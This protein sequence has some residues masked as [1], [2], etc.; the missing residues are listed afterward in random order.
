LIFRYPL[1]LT[2]GM[3]L[4]M[5]RKSFVSLC[6]AGIAAVLL[7]TV[8]VKCQQAA[9]APGYQVPP[10]FVVEKV[11]GPP[12]VRYPLFGA[13]DDKGRLYVAEGTGTNL[14]GTE[15]AKK[16]LGRILLLEDTD[17]DGRFDTS[18]VFADDL[19][20]PQG[21]LW[22]DGALYS[23]SHP[24]FWR[25]E[26]TKGTGKADRRIELAT[27][28]NFNG[29]GCDIHGP[30][31][32]PDGRLYWTDGR[33]GYKLRTREGKVLEGLASRIWRCRT[34]GSE[35]ERIA[36]GGFDNPVQVA[37]TPEGEVIGTMD[38]GQG[39]ALLHYVEGGV[40]PMDHPCL[41]E[42]VM[43]GPLLG[44]IRNYSA[45]L[46]AALCG[47]TAYRSE[48]LGKEFKDTFFSTQ[49]MLH[50]IVNHRMIRDGST[51]R[52]EDKDF[53]TSSVHDVHITDAFED[54]DGSLLFIDMGAWF[55]Y[56]FPHNPIPK[57]EV[58]GGIY[59]IRRTD[60]KPVADPWGKALKLAERTAAELTPMLDDPRPRV[61]DQV[62]ALL[63]KT[64]AEAVP[65]LKTIVSS[66][67]HSIEARRNAVWALC[68]IPIP[69]AR[70]AL[71]L[72]LADKELSVRLAA[73]H[74]VSVE[75]D[76][77]ASDALVSLVQSDEPP[78]RLKSAEALGRIGKPG[79]VPALLDSLRKGG[80]RFLE[81]ALIYALIRIN[82][83]AA[84]L[85][86]LE[87]LDPKVRQA[88][89]IAL[90][91]MPAG[92][93]TRDLVVPLLD[94]DDAGLQHTALAVI[95]KRPGWSDS[96]QGLLRQWLEAPKLSAA[97]ER[98]LTG[99]LL[100]FSGEG[101]IQKLVAESLA[102]EATA[103]ATQLLLLSVM[104]RCR[105]DALPETWLRAIEKGLDERNLPVCREAVATVKSR[106]L[107]GFDARLTALGR[108]ADLP[109]D[110]RIAAL[111]CMAERRQALDA[112]SYRLL[113][114]HL[115]EKT[116]PL[117]RLSAART[118]GGGRL[119]VDQLRQ[120]TTFLPAT[121]TMVLRL[122]LPAYAKSGDGG[123]GKALVAA[124]KRTPTAEALAVDELDKVLKR[125][126]PEV[127]QL[128]RP[129]LEKL[130]LGQRKQAEYL[131][132]L[133]AE[134]GQLQGSVD[135]GRGVFFSQKAACYACHRAAGKGGNVGPD[136]SKVGSF[137]NTHELLES[138]VF[139]NL[140]I[141]PEYRT[142]TIVTK[143]GRPYSG[144]IVRET[145]EALFLRTVQL[146]EIR[147]PRKDVDELAP[148]A[149]SLM[150][151]GL[152]RTLT[153][154]ELRDLL[155]FLYRQ[156]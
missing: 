58:L 126:S 76:E 109:A 42:F 72:A 39:D 9:P 115:S 113:T 24:S 98:S 106:S 153:R 105:L 19:V 62:I 123:T 40:Y 125:Y 89:L 56:G 82:D 30:F 136:L 75:R 141:A 21:V 46:P 17:G 128:G 132:S 43:T 107:K 108:Q 22:H 34:D 57:P 20:F 88:G 156:K 122:L 102:N 93:L 49:Y 25:F 50:R 120:L 26:D 31:L 83:R 67:K 103:T 138:I 112:D 154:Q 65:P 71:R 1:P 52:C 73:A 142:Y 143:A 145:S 18:K 3:L 13:F 104:A 11:A 78:L 150:P 77:G 27:R 54:A 95:S 117:L 81:H 10:G 61:R 80:D 155:E 2:A 133:R 29:N 12:L 6:P 121:S 5:N 149:I 37:F 79:A 74:A 96:I 99:A 135:A 45:A 151:E 147:L 101:N 94:T 69:E 146:A 110:L 144:M 36:G 90:D 140:T 127:Q 7:T 137:R 60:A 59:R 38:Q 8:S 119:S 63:A 41:K 152:E 148:A 53:L 48:V 32:G 92:K 100:G 134:L 15:L 28:F 35:L 86:A 84:T 55:T 111:E 47:F 91:Q 66:P 116:E 51:F 130:V 114:V 85:P 44:S 131:T 68:R 4:N 14:P 139:P 118:L 87:D 129:L 64:G 23:A 124:L 33:H 16:K 97:Q 70:S